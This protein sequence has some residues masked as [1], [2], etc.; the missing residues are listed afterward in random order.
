MQCVFSLV[1]ICFLGPCSEAILKVQLWAELLIR[2][3]NVLFKI[4]LQGRI[5]TGLTGFRNPLSVFKSIKLQGLR[6]KKR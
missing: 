1:N 3:M 5:Y 6:H 2:Y 4:T